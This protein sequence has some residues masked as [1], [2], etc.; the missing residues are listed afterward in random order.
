[1]QI[2]VERDVVLLQL[3]QGGNR[4]PATTTCR[5]PPCTRR[6]H[7]ITTIVRKLTESYGTRV[8]SSGR[9]AMLHRRFLGLN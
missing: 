2:A 7:T 1:M 8:R 6:R 5:L 3:R 9:C 4:L